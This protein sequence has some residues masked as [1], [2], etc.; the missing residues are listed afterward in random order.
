[1]HSLALILISSGQKK[2]KTIS[3]LQAALHNQS[4][5]HLHAAMLSAVKKTSKQPIN[6]TDNRS[7]LICLP[8]LSVNT[9]MKITRAEANRKEEFSSSSI[10]STD[11]SS[12][13]LFSEKFICGR[14]ASM[15]GHGETVA[16][17]WHLLGDQQ[18]W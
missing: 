5:I 2:A 15:Q 9:L 8:Y 3:A 13:Y 18:K 16:L 6:T 14:Y 12:N 10:S 4:H 11:W 7:A 17:D 1:M